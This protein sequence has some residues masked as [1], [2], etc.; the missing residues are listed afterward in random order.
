MSA[1]EFLQSKNLNGE[2]IP[3]YTVVEYLEEYGNQKAKE[4]FTETIQKIDK[5][6][7]HYEGDAGVTCSG[8]YPSRL[9]N[10]FLH[11]QQKA[12]NAIAKNKSVVEDCLV[13][14]RSVA[15]LAE[16][17]GMAQTHNEKN[18]RLRGLVELLESAIH[19]LRTHQEDE[20]MHNWQYFSWHVSDYPYRA[21]LRNLQQE[22]RELKA[23]LGEATESDLEESG[24]F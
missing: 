4:L 9:R 22:N 6:I 7:R 18:A 5:V 1:E 21:V 14:F 24:N 2:L 12:G 10:L 19:K 17:V 13:Y 15:M 16:S 20:L 11:Y 23:K 3:D 8:E